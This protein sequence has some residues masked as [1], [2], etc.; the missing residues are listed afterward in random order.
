MLSSGQLDRRTNI[1]RSFESCSSSHFPSLF[2]LSFITL[3]LFSFLFALQLMF[4]HSETHSPPPTH[5]PT[6]PIK[7][8]AVLDWTRKV[9]F[10]SNCA[11]THFCPFVAPDKA[12]LLLQNWAFCVS[13]LLFCCMAPAVLSY[14]KPQPCEVLSSLLFPSL[15]L[16][17]LH[18]TF[19]ITSSLDCSAVHS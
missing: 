18:F 3:F 11:S 6:L 8:L 5:P 13:F 1:T 17:C 19:L 2:N 10:P 9:D 12:N 15:I 7:E 16:S 4:F 14:C